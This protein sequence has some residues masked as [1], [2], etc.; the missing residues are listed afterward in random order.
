M[1]C[2][3]CGSKIP[4]GAAFC[5]MCGAQ[6]PTSSENAAITKKSIWKKPWLYIAAALVAAVAVLVVT[7]IAQ[8]IT[9]VVLGPPEVVLEHMPINN[10]RIMGK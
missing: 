8:P 2:A 9:N 1:N 10:G 4:D 6:R 5:I 7:G 3:N